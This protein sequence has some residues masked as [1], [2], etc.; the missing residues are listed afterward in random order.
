MIFQHVFFKAPQCGYLRYDIDAI[1]I[2]IRHLGETA[3]LARF[4]QEL[5]MSFC[6]PDR[7]R[8]RSSCNCPNSIPG[9]V[10]QREH[11]G[12][13]MPRLGRRETLPLENPSLLRG[14]DGGRI[15]RHFKCL[16]E[17]TAI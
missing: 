17:G 6:M 1:A 7:E 5:L 4:W 2:F 8:K 3:D 12:F 13:V 10:K 14:A 15:A 16:C 11:R 9:P